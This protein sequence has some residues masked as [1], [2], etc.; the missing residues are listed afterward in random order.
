MHLDPKFETP[1]ID[2]VLRN[3]QSSNQNLHVLSLKAWQDQ[4]NFYQ[5]KVV[6][7]CGVGGVCGEEGRK[8]EEE[9]EDTTNSVQD[10]SNSK[11]TEFNNSSSFAK[12][13][14]TAIFFTDI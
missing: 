3:L 10:T 8:E 7:F 5:W 4:Q 11:C 2:P 6:F 13:I 1:D 12:A 14:D 9:E